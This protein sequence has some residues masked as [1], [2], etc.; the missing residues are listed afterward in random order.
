MDYTICDKVIE[1]AKN[2][3]KYYIDL[4]Y[5][6]ISS[7]NPHKIILNDKILEKYHAHSTEFISTWLHLLSVGDFKKYLEI[8]IATSQN[9]FI[10]TCKISHDKMLIVREKEDYDEHLFNELNV[11]N[12]DEAISNI[13]GSQVIIYQSGTQNQISTGNQS[14]NTKES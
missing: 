12:S 10:E 11:I 2:G 5:P 8:N 4:L 14:P 9:V 7:S 13:R 3:N 1:T 6:L